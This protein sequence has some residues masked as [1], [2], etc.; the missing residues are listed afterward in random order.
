MRLLQ[1]CL[2]WMTLATVAALG[3]NNVFGVFRKR[4]R[5]IE[6]V[7]DKRVE[8]ASRKGFA[9]PNG[10]RLTIEEVQAMQKELNPSML[11]QILRVFDRSS[12]KS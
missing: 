1:V 2:M 7:Q 8:V 9:G 6:K 3:Q 10:E 5:S 12:K 4:R 11:D